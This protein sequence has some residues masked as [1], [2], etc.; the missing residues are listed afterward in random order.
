MAIEQSLKRKRGRPAGGGSPSA[1]KSQRDKKV[2]EH[3]IALVHR[4]LALLD[5]ES[6]KDADV[7]PTVTMDDKLA[8][9]VDQQPV[10]IKCEDIDDEDEHV[11]LRIMRSPRADSE[12][13]KLLD[14][15]QTH[16]A[17]DADTAKKK[18]GRLVNAK[19]NMG[20]NLKL[21]I[22][23]R[24]LVES[25]GSN[26][27][28]SDI[29]DDLVPMVAAVNCH[30][31]CA[32][33][34]GK[35][36]SAMERAKEVLLKLPAEHPSFVKHMLHSHVVQ[37]FWLGLPSNF[38]NKHL[39]KEDTT[40]VLEDE[41]RHNYDAKYLGAKQGL[42]AGWRGFAINHDIKV[43][44]VVVFQLVSSAKFK[45]YILR[46][47]NFTTTDGALGL[48]CL[49]AGKEK[50]LKES[51]NDVKPK[52]NRKVQSDSSNPASDSIIDGIRFSDTAI[53]FDHVKNFSNFNI[54]VDG[55]VIDCK[56][57]DHLRRTYYELCCARESFLH[58]DLLKQINLTLAV[59]V[60]METINI[61]EGIRAASASSHQD[62]LVWKKTLEAFQFLGMNV[63]FL[64][65]R[66]DDLLG[67]PARPRDPA[68]HEEKKEIKLEHARA[69]AKM[70]ELESRMSS[71][72]DTLKKMDVEMKELESSA[73]RTEEMRL[74][75][76]PW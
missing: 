40:I 8:A 54:I 37:G 39:P 56:F 2:M 30:K 12:Q 72:K 47:N 28:R 41:D 7:Q 26:S 27:R 66:I 59:G 17:Q 25:G 49:E 29:D 64:L 34:Q 23:R 70:K 35:F 75:T 36:G 44:D 33:V 50:I 6:D 48:L 18:G 43:G 65:K 53:D 57:P 76:A 73:K 24:T 16:N 21:S 42:S 13:K 22:P 63:E 4:R 71:V 9:V 20:Q 51:S 5:S 11:P 52:E 55:L 69:K 1:N 3:K 14:V 68:G 62:F 67:L 31:T 46:A 45:V 74:A 32:S 10:I 38:C 61:A 60:I 19:S 15:S 58:K